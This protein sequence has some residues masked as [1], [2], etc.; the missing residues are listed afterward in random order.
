MLLV[1]I[2]T[3]RADHVGAYGYHEATSPALDGLAARGTRFENA[4]SAAPLTGPSHATIF[5]GHYPP[6]HGVRDNARFVINPGVTTLAERL[7]R[8]GYETAAFVGAFP[9]AAAF[10]FGRGFDTF[11]EGFHPSAELGSVAERPAVEVAEAAI[12]WLSGHRRP[13]FVWVHFFDPHEPYKPPAPYTERFASAYDGEIAFADAQLGRVLDALRSA[14]HQ[15]DT[16]VVVLSDHGEGLGQH[17]ETTHGLLLY[18]S[19]LRVPLVMAGPGVPQGRVLRERVGTVDVLP[20][21][22][23]LI[24]QP[25]PAGLP[26]GDLGP[27]MRGRSLAAQP[28]YS[29]SLYGRL[30]CRW[31]PLRGWTDR[32]WKLTEGNGAALFD[33][34]VDPGERQDRARQNPERA[35]QLRQAL[36]RAMRAMAPDGDRARPRPIGAS[37]AEALRSLGYVAGGAGAGELDE[38]G[39]PDPRER[40][41]FFERLRELSGASG[42]QVAAAMK[43]VTELARGDP[44]NPFVHEVLAG[45]SLRA[46]RLDLAASALAAFLDIEP[47]RSDVRTQRGRL[48]QS[49][50]RLDEAEQELRR[51]LANGGADA[52]TRVTLADTLVARGRTQEAEPLLREVLATDPRHHLGSLALGRL[53]V[54]QGRVMEAVPLFESA[55]AGGD[56]EALLELAEAFALAGRTASSIETAKRVLA[57]SPAHPWALSLLG[58]ALVLEGDREDGEALLQRALRASPR[59]PRVWLR[60]AEGFHALGRDDLAR[61]CRAAASARATRTRDLR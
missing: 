57:A 34:S 44:G 8:A 24:G 28:L 36:H 7:R 47:G 13:F 25:V 41:P 18:E 12:R 9:V 59:R 54:A 38:P 40:L 49:L 61:R 56:T 45:L 58:H 20:T 53:R 55:A 30:N 17:G 60:L 35:G 51:A 33:L 22:L 42:P 26:G 3:L 32:D 21:L 14:G 29:E 19:T 23:A 11:D 1:T 31:A 39:L 37:E 4:Q 52:L 48:L 10:G 43:Q 15:D 46:G 2:D 27:V 6:V 50:G 5:T 16:I